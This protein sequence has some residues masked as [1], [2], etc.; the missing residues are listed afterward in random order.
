MN[1]DWSDGNKVVSIDPNNDS[2]VH[3]YEVGSGPGNLLVHDHEVY[4]SRTYYDEYWN[5]FYGT[6]KII[7]E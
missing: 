6:S 5:A 4:I 7:L 2:I 3:V 1:E